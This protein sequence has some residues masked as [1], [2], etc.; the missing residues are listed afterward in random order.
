VAK[1]NASG[2]LAWQKQFP[3]TNKQLKCYPEGIG[4]DIA[5]DP[6]GNVIITGQF[7]GKYSFGSA[8]G[9]TISSTSTDAFTTKFNNAGNALWVKTGTGSNVELGNAV[10]TDDAGNVYT[11]GPFGMTGLNNTISFGS[12]QLTQSGAPNPAFLVKYSSLGNVLW[13]VNPYAGAP[14]NANV[15]KILPAF[16]GSLMIN[17]N[18]NGIRTIDQANGFVLG[19]IDL[20][21]NADNDNVMPT[22]GLFQMHDIAGDGDNFISSLTGSCGHIGFGDITITV[23]GCTDCDDSCN[24]NPT[25]KYIVQGSLEAPPAIGE[26][27]EINTRTDSESFPSSLFDVFPNPATHEVTISG[28]Q[29]APGRQ[30]IL[31][32]QLGQIMQTH[33]LDESTSSFT[34]NLDDDHLANGLYF[35]SLKTGDML[36]TQKLVI[37]R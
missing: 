12:V 8:T 5:L 35:I 3:N 2:T 19:S 14:L 13:A 33:L 1:L 36:Q 31:Y 22:I 37:T 21:G 18:Y 16:A 9:L 28:L 17:D 34:V 6:T 23:P 11:G 27:T 25:D 26:G 32:N 30:L 10:Y 20:L 4:N 7:H 24:V 29:L 15:R